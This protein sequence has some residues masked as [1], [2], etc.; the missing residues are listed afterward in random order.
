M[1][2][3]VCPKGADLNIIENVWGRMK[4]AMARRPLHRATADELWRFVLEE[5]E[6]LRN[7][8]NSISALFSS[9]PARMRAVVDVRGEM[10]SY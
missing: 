9:L 10:T 1:K 7:E 6:K 3:N 4:A 5:W 8:R 2:G